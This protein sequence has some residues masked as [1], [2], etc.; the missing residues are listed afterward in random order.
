MDLIMGVFARPVEGGRAA[1]A[2]KKGGTAVPPE[3][4]DNQ[5]GN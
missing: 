1:S 3:F 4:I 2:H 5:S